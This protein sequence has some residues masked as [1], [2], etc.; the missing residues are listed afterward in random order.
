MSRQGEC[1]CT[2]A[3]LSLPQ[4]S[5]CAS[6]VKANLPATGL[7][8]YKLGLFA[9]HGGKNVTFSF[10]SFSY[11]PISYLATEGQG[12]VQEYRFICPSV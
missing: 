10:Y 9:M 2:Q 8:S 11:K 12:V 3:F 5:L 1:L 7:S 4:V 6:E